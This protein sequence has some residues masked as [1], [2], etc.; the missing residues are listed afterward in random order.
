[1]ATLDKTGYRKYLTE[2]GFKDEDITYDQNTQSVMAKGKFFGNAAPAADGSTYDT[3]GNLESMYKAYQTQNMPTYQ[4]RTNT[5]LDQA[6]QKLGQPAKPFHY[7][8]QAD[9]LYL[10]ALNAAQTGAATQQGN[11]LAKLRSM[12]QGKS[13]YSEGVASQI[14]QQAVAD[15]N[16][17]VLPQLTSQAYQRYM[18]EQQLGRQNFGDTLQLAGTYNNLG[19]QGLDNEF[20]NQQFGEQKKQNNLAAASQ[21]GQQLGRV[22]QPKD[23]YGNLYNQ[24]DAP[25]NLQGQQIE[26][27]KER[28]QVGDARYDQQFQYQQQQDSAKMQQQ[29]QQFAASQGLDWARLNQQQQQFVAEQ[30]YREQQNTQQVASQNAER[31]FDRGIELYKTTGQM[32]SFMADYG[33]DVKGLSSPQYAEDL[34]AMYEMLSAGQAKPQDLIKSIDDKVKIGAER[35]E[36][37]DRMKQAIYKLYPNLDPANKKQSSGENPML[38]T[39]GENAVFNGDWLKRAAALGVWGLSKVTGN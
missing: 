37:G 30:A 12:G 6:Q 17:K 13:S 26:Y 23:D 8:A 38:S 34:S 2:K 33:I 16:S 7:N 1:M 28:D 25:L 18:D 24:A 9:P 5:L 36:D 31:N 15:V 22:I 3:R 10:N 32:P 20:R 39:S 4:D 21:V 11:T 29:A 19:Q 27:Q 14:G 35:A